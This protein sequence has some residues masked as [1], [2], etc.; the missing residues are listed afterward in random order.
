MLIS[1]VQLPTWNLETINRSRAIFTITLTELIRRGT[2][3]L[4]KALMALETA[5]SIAELNAEKALI[6]TYVT[7]AF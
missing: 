3:G 1:G 5:T 6:W 2:Y 4:S 7:L